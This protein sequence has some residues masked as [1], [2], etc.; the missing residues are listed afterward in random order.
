MA[1]SDSRAGGG[2]RDG[3]GLRKTAPID[4]GD[5]ALPRILAA[6]VESLDPADGGMWADSLTADDR[7]RMAAAVARR[8]LQAPLDREL[9][10][11]LVAAVLPRSLATLVVGEVSQ[12]RFVERIAQSLLDDPRAVVRLQTLVAGLRAE[13][14]PPEGP[15]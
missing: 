13:A 14:R 9:A 5:G 3:G 15:P 11:D 2:Q 10:A 12:R 8:G 6:A 7:R 4:G 1:R